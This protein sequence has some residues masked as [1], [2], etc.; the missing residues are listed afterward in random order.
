MQK[1]FLI[2]YVLTI[3]IASITPGP[4]TLL[5]FNH[6]L[7]FGVKK[8]LMTALGTTIAI[9][10]QGTIAMAGLGVL[11]VQSKKIYFVIKLFGAIYLVYL[12][13]KMFLSKSNG[14]DEEV[15]IISKQKKSLELLRDSLVVGIGNP[16][17]IIFF[18]AL[19]PQFLRNDF[20]SYVQYGIMLMIISIIT[21]LCMVLYSFSGAKLLGLFRKRAVQSIFNKVTGGI[22][23][24]LGVAIAIEE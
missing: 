24:S 5:A 4:G 3:F 14:F 18:T 15:E 16:K 22:F 20:K 13:I 2:T 6:G 7:K 17:A 19:F 8:S 11:L 21:F 23:I 12:G 1:G 9:S 10:L